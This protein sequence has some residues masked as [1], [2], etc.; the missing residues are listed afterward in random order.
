MNSVRLK[1]SNLNLLLFLSLLTLSPDRADKHISF[2]DLKRVMINHFSRF[3]QEK[4]RDA[5]KLEHPRVTS[6]TSL[7]DYVQRKWE[8]LCYVMPALVETQPGYLI[9][10]VIAGIEDPKIRVELGELKSSNF[11]LLKEHAATYDRRNRIFNPTQLTDKQMA[12]D[13]K[14]YID[15]LKRARKEAAIETAAEVNQRSSATAGNQRSS[16]RNLAGNFTNFLNN[17][18]FNNT[19]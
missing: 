7:E 19:N 4:M 2:G 15:Q 16:V 18:F 13:V 8:Y 9:R 10:M 1:L 12:D 17:S 11:N 6:T 5:L 14:K 3:K